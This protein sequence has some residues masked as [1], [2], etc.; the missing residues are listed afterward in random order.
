MTIA[1]GTN[2][3][4]WVD[5]TIGKAH[6]PGLYKGKVVVAAADKPLASLPIEIEVANAILPDRPVRTMLYY[7][8]TE[9]ERRIG[10]GDAAEQQLWKL[11]HRHRLSALHG[12]KSADDVVH[13]LSALDGS[14]YTAAGDYDGPGEG[15]GD[16]VLA[17]GTYGTLGAPDAT[18]L[19]TV[20]KIADLLASKALVDTTD[21]FVYA[22]DEDCKSP[23]GAKWKSLLGASTNPNLKKVRVAWTCSEDAASQPVDIPIQ[24]ATFDA[25]KS[26]RAREL[27]KEV[28]AYNGK[29]PQ[30]GTFLTDTAAIAPRVNGWLSAMFDIGRWFYWETTFWYDG[31]RGGHGAYDPFVT[32]ETFHNA[33]GD[34]CMGDGVLVYPG[35]Q[36]DGFT[37]HSL[38]LDG[39]IPSIRLKNW[40]RGIEDAGYYQLA[41]A[42]NAA[43]AEAIAK[44]LLPIVTS[45]AKDGRPPSWSESGKAF[46]DA[47]KALL[48]L[49]PAGTNGGE[50]SGAR[51]GTATTAPSPRPNVA[52]GGGCGSGCRGCAVGRS[53]NVE[54]DGA[55]ALGLALLLR[56][57]RRGSRSTIQ[58]KIGRRVGGC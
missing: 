56:R 16:G 31:N 37:S 4:V 51:P 5:V 40:R 34:Y 48:A 10:G 2:G 45:A 46:F 11:L 6:P 22:Q 41:H 3:I 50:G 30:T 32:A 18:T 36:V 38:G 58:W 15:M 49:V 47:R 17:I 29:L 33:D 9:L 55:L 20:E 53:A 35:K 44:A 54:C 52:Q 1:P 24:A 26:A 7:A 39:V 21:T 57:Y 25:A 23:Y 43:K 8:R 12:A 28:W 13:H 14:L 27:G 42:A 19:A